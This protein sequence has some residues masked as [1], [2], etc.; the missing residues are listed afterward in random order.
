MASLDFDLKKL[1]ALP[2]RLKVVFGVLAVELIILLSG[3][4]LLDDLMA[5]RVAE[6]DRLRANLTQLR[7]KNTQQRQDLDR[8]P[9]LRK[10]YDEAIAAGLGSP[11]D[12]AGVVNAARDWS[13]NHRLVDLRYRLVPDTAKPAGSPRY[14]IENDLVE[15]ECGALVDTDILSFWS[16]VLAQQAGHYR[17][18]SFAM[19]RQRALD[20]SVLTAVRHGSVVA[21]L[22][23]KI[24]LVWT[25]AEPNL[26]G[27]Q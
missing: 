12:R 25:G 22:Q 17:I 11:L 1:R 7:H 10:H 9:L 8:Y 14:V 24:G 18:A 15:F 16:N 5:D 6:V 4:L 20:E 26:Q 27:R 3:Y 23:S 19:E 21:L 13:D 2:R